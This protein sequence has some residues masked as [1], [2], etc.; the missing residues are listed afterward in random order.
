[1][2]P[3]SLHY[4]LNML[5][6][7]TASL[8]FAVASWAVTRFVA[9][10]ETKTSLVNQQNQA[11]ITA[12][13]DDAVHKSI[14]FGLQQCQSQI[15][16][17]GWADAQV[18]SSAISAALNYIGPH[19]PGY[20]KAIGIDPNDQGEIS[21]FVSGALDRA[22]PNAVDEASRSPATPPRGNS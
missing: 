11:Q 15:A 14:I 13:F 17:L 22:F 6:N 8:L 5:A 2:D 4:W 7:L 18:K 19:F 3:S 21:K 20:L 10:L 9:W 16:N 1:M 12:N